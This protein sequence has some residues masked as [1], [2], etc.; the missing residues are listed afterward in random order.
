M[1]TVCDLF[2][3]FSCHIFS[4]PNKVLYMGICSTTTFTNKELDKTKPNYNIHKHR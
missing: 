4:W 2:P 3:K 1:V